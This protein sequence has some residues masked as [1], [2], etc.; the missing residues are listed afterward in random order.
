MFYSFRQVR[1]KHCSEKRHA[2]GTKFCPNT[3]KE[4]KRD[5]FLRPT[6]LFLAFTLCALVL[7]IHLKSESGDEIAK[8]ETDIVDEKPKS[9]IVK[10]KI[11]DIVR[12]KNNIAKPC[13]G[14]DPAFIPK[15]ETGIVIDTNF[16]GKYVKIEFKDR[17]WIACPEEIEKM[18]IE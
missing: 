4:I 5:S 9:Q 3:G 15:G 2:K 12:I 13:A 1:C 11:G 16:M 7:F 17:K 18:K 10:F 8:A 6:V 14:G